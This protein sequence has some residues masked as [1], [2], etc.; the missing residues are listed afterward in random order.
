MIVELSSPLVALVLNVGGWIVI[1]IGVSYACSRMPDH[2][3]EG[4]K[5][6]VGKDPSYLS[7]MW[8]ER[9]YEKVLRIRQWKDRVP[10]GGKLFK[11]GFLKKKLLSQDQAYYYKY[12]LETVRGEWAHWLSI[13]PAP[14]FFIWNT[15]L[16]GWLMVVYAL[17]A[18]L[19]FIAIQ[20]Y[21]RIRLSRVSYHYAKKE[22]KALSII[23]H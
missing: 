17:A 14:F 10:D 15:P 8:E 4:N 12:R 5:T 22:K 7:K 1:H 20:R 21:N 11:G 6:A 19:P 16:Y 23:N 13:A 18:N 2:W 9:F 3:F